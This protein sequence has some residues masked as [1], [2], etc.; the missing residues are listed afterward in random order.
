MSADSNEIAPKEAVNEHAEVA[1]VKGYLKESDHSDTI[2]LYAKNRGEVVFA[3]LLE[4]DPGRND[5]DPYGAFKE[6]SEKMLDTPESEAVWKTLEGGA[7]D[8]EAFCKVAVP[9]SE[10]VKEYMSKD[11][12]DREIEDYAKE[13][14]K[15][16]VP[17]VDRPLMQGIAK[18]IEKISEGAKDLWRGKEPALSPEEIA[19]RSERFNKVEAIT[20]SRVLNMRERVQAVPAREETREQAAQRELIVA[21]LNLRSREPDRKDITQ[22]LR[23]KYGLITYNRSNVCYLTDEHHEEAPAVLAAVR[24]NLPDLDQYA[25][26]IDPTIKS[27]AFNSKHVEVHHG[28]IPTIGQPRDMKALSADEAKIYR[29]ISQRYV[30]QFIKPA[31]YDQFSVVFNVGGYLFSSGHLFKSTCRTLI[32]SGWQ[33]LQGKGG[34]DDEEAKG[35]WSDLAV[36]QE[37]ACNAITI[38]HCETKP[39]KRYTEKALLLDLTQVAK[40]V[41]DER[42]KALLKAKDADLKSE[43]GARG[44]RHAGH[45]RY[46][47]RELAQA[48]VHRA[49]K[50]VLRQYKIGPR[51]DRRVAGI[52]DQARH[53]RP[54]ARAATKHRKG[55][56]V[57]QCFPR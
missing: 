38:K 9:E 22:S 21:E 55:R 51:P 41:D 39:P 23:D 44:H 20:E 46:D 16:H 17:L 45:T 25:A 31:E 3:Q 54:M 35:D 27:K 30:M 1:L 50:E 10:S 12:R 11:V 26:L 56:P 57:G 49:P 33:A 4:P 36:G 2:V 48:P 14:V 5:V 24:K 43:H 42:I 18:G 47:D 53:D 13:P 19:E 40:Y 52:D 7:K 8:P 28:I 37:G 15:E 34:A 32:A 6:V 29:L